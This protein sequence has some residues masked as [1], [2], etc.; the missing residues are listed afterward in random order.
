MHT[1]TQT[2]T[3]THSTNGASQ[4]VLVVKNLP[5]S[6]EDLRDEGSVCGLERS[7]G[8]RHSKPLQYSCLENSKDRGTWQAIVRGGHKEWDTTEAT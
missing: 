2:H 5:A 8:R 1:H 6:A 7:L 3:H 4:A